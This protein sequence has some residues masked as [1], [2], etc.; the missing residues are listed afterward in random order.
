[1]WVACRGDASRH[2]WTPA[3]QSVGPAMFKVGSE[4]L[5]MAVGVD[6]DIGHAPK[7]WGGVVRELMEASRRRAIVSSELPFSNVT[8]NVFDRREDF[9]GL[10]DLQVSSRRCAIEDLR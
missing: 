5:N 7:V 10:V 3:Q 9:V 2:L 8:L 4:T 6:W 1:M